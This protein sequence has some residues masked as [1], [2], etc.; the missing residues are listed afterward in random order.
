MIA[1][2]DPLA[3]FRA[4]EDAPGF[5]HQ[6]LQQVEFPGR[7]RHGGSPAGHA[8]VLH[9]HLQ[10]GDLEQICGRWRGRPPAQ[11]FDPRNQFIQ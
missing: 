6:H 1:L 4:G 11:G 2:P 9:I 10:I 3:E 5:L 8:A 7:Q